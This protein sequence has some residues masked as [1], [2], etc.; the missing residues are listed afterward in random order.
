MEK[1]N[2]ELL[3]YE[4]SIY[5]A[6]ELEKTSVFEAQ[7]QFFQEFDRLH[8]EYIPL[9]DNVFQEEHSPQ[10]DRMYEA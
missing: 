1:K 7:L 10:K 4:M 3:D 6:E 8:Q 2:H 9:P 5:T